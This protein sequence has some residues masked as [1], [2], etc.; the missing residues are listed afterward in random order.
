LFYNGT[1]SQYFEAASTRLNFPTTPF[2]PIFNYTLDVRNSVER[3]F[4][5][6]FAASC[7]SE[8]LVKDVG[9]PLQKVSSKIRFSFTSKALRS[10]I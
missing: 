6:R 4:G 7:N 9:S 2:H 5:F 3:V 10:K 8:Q 1:Q